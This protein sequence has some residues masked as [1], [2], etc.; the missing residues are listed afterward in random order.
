MKKKEGIL[1]ALLVV[2]IITALAVS[3][4]VFVKYGNKPITEIPA[5]ALIFMLG[6]GK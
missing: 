4:T 2:I 3:I 6:G 1:I 5:W